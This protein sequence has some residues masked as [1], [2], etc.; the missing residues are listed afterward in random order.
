[1]AALGACTAMTIRMYAEWHEL[2]LRK[3]TVR[4]RYFKLPA[5]NDTGTLDY[6]ER[7]IDLDGDLSEEQR[8][9]LLQISEKCPV[10]ETLHHS[11]TIDSRLAAHQAERM[12]M[13]YD[14]FFANALARLRDEQH[15][16]V[17]VEIDRIAGQC[18][19]AVWQSPRGPRKIVIWCSNDYLPMSQ[20]PDASGPATC[21]CSTMESTSNPSI[22]RRSP[23]EPNV[24]ASRRRPCI[25]IH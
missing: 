13:T 14:D 11:V 4:L 3:T 21:F 23:R 22:V 2:K 1:M 25:A 12:P 8:L 5:T 24:F 16:R 6:F 17:F 19:F 7:T 9:R 18:P 20:H 10:S 15:H